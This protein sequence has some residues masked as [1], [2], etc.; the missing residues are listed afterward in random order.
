[1]SR[2]L[3]LNTQENCRRSLARILRGFTS[4][5]REQSS[6]AVGTFRAQVFAFATLLQFHKLEQDSEI[7][8][9]FEALEGVVFGDSARLAQIK[10]RAEQAAQ[11][12]RGDGQT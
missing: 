7:V 12:G 3:F 9:R 11:L 4:E 5:G 8:K 1:V 10:L 6:E 2:R